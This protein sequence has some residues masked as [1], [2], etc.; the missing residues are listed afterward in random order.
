VLPLPRESRQVRRVRPVRP[1]RRH[2]LRPQ[3]RER[4]D[5]ATRPVHAAAP[6][7]H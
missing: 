7:K 4:R 1:V 6:Q 5:L 2:V 3:L